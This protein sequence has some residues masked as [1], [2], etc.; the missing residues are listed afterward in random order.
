MGKHLFVKK[1]KE[2]N[3]DVEAQLDTTFVEASQ[4]TVNIVQAYPDLKKNLDT[5]K[6]TEV[7]DFKEHFAANKLQGAHK[8]RKARRSVSEKRT[9]ME[10]QLEE[11]RK[12][13][14]QKSDGTKTL[15]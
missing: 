8:A 4:V 1:Y 13:A 3:P 2:E 12:S 11:L 10:Q 7:S 14:G 15:S 9:V 5:S 6:N